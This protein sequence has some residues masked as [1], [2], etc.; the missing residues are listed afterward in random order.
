MLTSGYRKGIF[1]DVS[2]LTRF[3]LSSLDHF[4]SLNLP[5]SNALKQFNKKTD[6][7]SE[8][9]TDVFSIMFNMHIIYF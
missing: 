4:H 1:S 9:F 8:L 7:Y 5:F 3:Y 6:N 2:W